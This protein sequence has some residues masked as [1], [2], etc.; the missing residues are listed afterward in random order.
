MKKLVLLFAALLVAGCSEE[1]VTGDPEIDR[2]IKEAIDHDSLTLVMPRVAESLEDC[3][4]HEK[5]NDGSLLRHY[6]QPFSG[7]AKTTY[8]SGR[9]KSLQ[10]YKEGKAD[11][12]KI[13]WYESGQ[14]EL[15]W[16]W[17]EGEAY[18]LWQSWH[19]NGIR[20]H[21]LPFK[22]GKRDGQEAQWDEDGRLASETWHKKGVLQ[23][24]NLWHPNGQRLAEWIYRDGKN[25]SSEKYWSSKGEAVETY[26]E[27]KK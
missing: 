16:R 11:G 6:S 10:Q 8:D 2:A 4:L 26:E 1:A 5:R 21:K 14:K 22:N 9:V 27:A 24:V 25:K 3:L 23:F 17:K 20:S 13:W 12:L 7:W 19:E 18:G 15:E